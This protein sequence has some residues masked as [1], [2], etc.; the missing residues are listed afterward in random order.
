MP[1]LSTV[2]LSTVRSAGSA[3][4]TLTWSARGHGESETQDF[5][6][7]SGGAQARAPASGLEFEDC[8]AADIRQV[9]DRL[10]GEVQCESAF[11]QRAR[12]ARC[13]SARFPSP[14]GTASRGGHVTP[15]WLLGYMGSVS[16]KLRQWRELKLPIADMESRW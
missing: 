4:T 7:C 10:L 1:F 5:R 15:K 14:S 12:K 11:A 6:D 13:G 8:T 9:G 2:A 16:Q 3:V